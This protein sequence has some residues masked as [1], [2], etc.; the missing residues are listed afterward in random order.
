MNNINVLVI[1]NNIYIKK[2]LLI[3]IRIR[4]NRKIYENTIRQISVM[5]LILMYVC[6]HNYSL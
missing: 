5:I 3:I 1:I 6:S 2:L 4:M